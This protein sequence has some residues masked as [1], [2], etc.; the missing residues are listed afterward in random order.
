[1]K[2][3]RA[4]NKENAEWEGNIFNRKLSIKITAQARAKW[5]RKVFRQAIFGAYYSH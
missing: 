1:M 3:E 4:S 5:R 2:T